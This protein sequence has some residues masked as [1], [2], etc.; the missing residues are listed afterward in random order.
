VKLDLTSGEYTQ[1]DV[2]Q[3]LASGDDSTHTQLRVANSGIAYLSK[4]V[5]SDNLGGVALRFETWVAGNSY[6]GQDAGA[7]D[8]W[9][10]RIYNALKENWPNPK[11][12]YLDM[13]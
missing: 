4:D 9:V 8:A 5:G 7:D 6:V 3:L 1:N 11:H 13:F 2:A 12:S 10:G